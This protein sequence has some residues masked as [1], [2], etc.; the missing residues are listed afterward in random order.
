MEVSA[1][2]VQ[3][4]AMPWQG[5]AVY[6]G[7]L[8]SSRANAMLGAPDRRLVKGRQ[9]QAGRDWAGVDDRQADLHMQMEWAHRALS[10]GPDACLRVASVDNDWAGVD[11]R[12]ADLHMQMEWAQGPV[13]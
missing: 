1:C 9:L 8:A 13:K 6:S 7:R 5:V 12:Q 3:T 2:A 4:A 10:S 11:D